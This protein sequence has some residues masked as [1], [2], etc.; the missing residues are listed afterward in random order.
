MTDE[1]REVLTYT[2]FEKSDHDGYW[3]WHTEAG[4]NEIVGDGAEG[5][6][7]LSDCIKG[8]FVQQGVNI[9]HAQLKSDY[10]SLERLTKIKY[11]ITKY[12]PKNQN[13]EQE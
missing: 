12:A 6:H 1:D 8:F 9:D 2:Y 10:G 11:L 5:Y 4:N 3:Y 7:E 13:S